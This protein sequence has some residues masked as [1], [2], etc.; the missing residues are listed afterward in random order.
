MRLKEKVKEERKGKKMEV[1]LNLEEEKNK[2]RK[3]KEN[4][5]GKYLILFSSINL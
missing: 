2:E 5:R 1:F 4:K 3:R